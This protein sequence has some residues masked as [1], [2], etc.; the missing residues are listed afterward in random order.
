[1]LCV[2]LFAMLLG[3]LQAALGVEGKHGW[4]ELL[5]VRLSGKCNLD[6]L[7]TMAAIAYKC[8][9]KVG[10]KRPKIR[11][12]AQSLS[13]LGRKKSSSGKLDTAGVKG[14]HPLAETFPEEGGEWS[15][16]YP[17]T[18]TGKLEQHVPNVRSEHGSP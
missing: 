1:M 11:D 5:D 10:K 4:A 17:H 9:R 7:G 14:L 6:D 12:V 15:K 2:A 18:E 13:K 16:P 3:H 8:V